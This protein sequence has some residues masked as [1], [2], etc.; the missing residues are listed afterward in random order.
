[1]KSIGL[2]ALFFSV[3]SQIIF[4]QKY[5]INQWDD[6]KFLESLSFFYAPEVREHEEEKIPLANAQWIVDHS[7]ISFNNQLLVT[8]GKINFEIANLLEIS[9]FGQ[10][11]SVFRKNRNESTLPWLSLHIP[12]RFQ[13]SFDGSK[14]A[15]P[16]CYAH[17]R[18]SQNSKTID[19]SYIFFYPYNGAIQSNSL[20]FTKIFNRLGTGKHEGDIEHITVRLDEFGE[21][22]LGVFYASHG[23]TEGKWYTHQGE[24]EDKYGYKINDQGQLITWTALYTHGNHNRAGV[25]KRKAPIPFKNIIGGLGILVDKTSD[26]GT[27]YNCRELLE[28]LPDEN[29]AP[30]S[31]Y[32][33]NFRGTWGLFNQKDA[34]RGFVAPFGLLDKD[35][36]NEEPFG[37]KN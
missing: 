3:I 35:W 8:I 15:L 30:K 37:P 18:R 20:I 22:I 34:K 19:I 14:R 25:I 21:K 13:H 32:W 7:G 2:K 23:P 6:R 33:M 1:M 27:H 16:K 11:E 9:L 17:A 12:S 28:I 36:W 26:Y 5:L 4:G 31:H 10:K 24:L 29:P